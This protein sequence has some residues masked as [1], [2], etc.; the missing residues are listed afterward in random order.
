MI[1]QDK[2]ESIN[3]VMDETEIEY[4]KESRI[5][6]EDIIKKKD[7]F[8]KKNP[9][10][11][12]YY[13][14]LSNKEES[15][16]IMTQLDKGRKMGEQMEKKTKS[17][18][19]KVN[20]TLSNSTLM[21]SNLVK[22]YKKNGIFLVNDGDY[23][24][25]KV[26]KHYPVSLYNLKGRSFQVNVNACIGQWTGF[27]EALKSD[28]A[29]FTMFNES[30]KVWLHLAEKEYDPTN[31]VQSFYDS[32]MND[33]RINATMRK[34]IGALESKLVLG[35]L[36]P[37]KQPA[38]FKKK[39]LEIFKLWLEDAQE[40]NY[41]E[42][43]E[44]ELNFSSYENTY[45]LARS[46]K[47]K[48]SIFVGPT[49]SGKTHAALNEL[50]KGSNGLY[51]APLRLMA[52]EGQEA[53]ADRG[54]L[55]NLITGEEQQLVPYAT[56][57]SSTVEMCNFNHVVEACVIDEIQMLADPS[58]G[59]AWSQ[60]VIGVPAQHVILVGSDEIL[61][62]LIP[63][64]EALGEEYEI[65]NFER[66]TPLNVREPLSKIGDLKANDCV[67][68]FSRKAALEMKSQV[69]A[70]G[71]KCSVIYGNLSPEVRRAEAAKF[72]SGENE[73][74]VATDAIGM[75]LNLPIQRIFF[76]T[77]EKF[78][79]TS[80]RKLNVTEVK[81]I[82]GRA[83]RYGLSTHGE[84]GLLYHG[85]K[86]DMDLLSRSIYMG[87]SALKDTRVSIA[88]NLKQV[89]K[90]CDI[91]DKRSVYSALIFFREKLIKDS[92]L[93]KTANLE[94]MIE[95]AGVLKSKEMPL[96][97]EFTYSCVPID[98]SMEDHYV[99]FNRWVN[100]HMKGIKN[101]PP[102]LPEEMEISLNKT[103]S[104]S[105]YAVENYVKICMAYR[106]LHYKYPD[107]YTQM[108]V[109]VE[110]A[111]KANSYIEQALER[112]LALSKLVTTIKYKK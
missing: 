105:L 15:D 29:N 52:S 1:L 23:S 65:Q 94:S 2:V 91:I 112:S 50:Q 5:S 60:A 13:K 46:L 47:R 69:E 33:N 111:K 35:W 25:I 77:M 68:V 88:P 97:N 63:L 104:Y 32:L 92:D 62:M 78:D 10:S 8:H 24:S 73:V 61:P 11:I 66:K 93:Y 9:K 28:A 79:G 38:G 31:D 43:I 100:N 101:I 48:F 17:G 41:I 110:N 30:L 80:S 74:L 6:R 67:V 3:L 57:T 85:A 54:I 76:S 12:E 72:K 75:G 109:A 58:R 98:P 102:A 81:Q 96:E 51:L 87:H 64:I 53:L 90:I 21:F 106:W 59:W 39:G 49:N 55:S 40:V 89:E 36:R 37:G 18:S 95:L 56:H 83:G 84:V 19:N 71:K 45:P 22:T 26:Y 7:F 86:E 107:S 82:S 16:K 70:T 44:T 20:K 14:G 27:N 108:E 34:F 42:K 103:T 99:M 4:T